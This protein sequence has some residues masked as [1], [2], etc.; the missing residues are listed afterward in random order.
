MAD[1]ER[2][3]K[4]RRGRVRARH[5]AIPVGR[6]QELLWMLRDLEDAKPRAGVARIVDSPMAVDVTGAVCAHASR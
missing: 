5:S 2:A 3:V 1:L 4:D 6:T